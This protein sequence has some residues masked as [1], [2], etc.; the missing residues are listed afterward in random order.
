ML[1]TNAQQEFQKQCL[2]FWMVDDEDGKEL[3]GAG[4]FLDLEQP[5]ESK[6]RRKRSVQEIFNRK[7]NETISVQKKVI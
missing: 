7:A 3:L 6:Q 2:D 5:M 1:L 4:G